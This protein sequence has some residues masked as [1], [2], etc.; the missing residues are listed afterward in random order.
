MYKIIASV[1]HS[2]FES[3]TR[4]GVLSN[5]TSSS[6]TNCQNFQKDELRL[7]SAAEEAPRTRNLWL[8]SV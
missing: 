7:E 3:K 2:P 6:K 5:V 8:W 4:N 1:C